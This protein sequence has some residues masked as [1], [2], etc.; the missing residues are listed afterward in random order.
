MKK[1]IICR[2]LLTGAKRN[3]ICG[4]AWCP[5]HDMKTVQGKLDMLH[6]HDGE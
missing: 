4:H 3:C 6:S 1:C 2:K 5:E